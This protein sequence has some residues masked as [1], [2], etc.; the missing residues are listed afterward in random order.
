MSGVHPAPLLS[1]AHRRR[2]RAVWRSAGWPC[3]DALEAELLA[4]GLLDEH[5]DTTG[6]A[7][8]RLSAAGVAALARST[9]LHRAARGG[10]ETLVDAVARSMQRAGRLV[11][12]GLALR[13]PLPGVDGATR[14]AIAMPDVYSIRP[15][16]LEDRVEPVV[17]EIKVRRADLLSDLRRPDK[18]NAYRALAAQCWYVLR[19]GIAEP[20]EVPPSFGVLV[21]RATG[22]LTLARPAPPQP[23]RLAV[24]TWVALARATPVED[25]LADDQGALG[26]TPA[27]PGDADGDAGRWIDPLP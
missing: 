8:L 15:S 18:G 10:H 2:L 19:D 20:D 26:T 14:W 16:P 12:R 21:A 27:S 6:R 22:A 11:W 4:A 25:L 1:T 24:A 13:A 9:E 7:T 17:H 5:C 23:M 3:R